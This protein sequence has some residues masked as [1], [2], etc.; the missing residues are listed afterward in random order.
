MSSYV[1]LDGTANLVDSFDDEPEARNAL[2]KIAREAPEAADEYAMIE[3]DD[4]GHPVG[5]ALIA[6]DLSVRA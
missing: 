5:E 4:A 2:E 6:S 3:Y 1:I